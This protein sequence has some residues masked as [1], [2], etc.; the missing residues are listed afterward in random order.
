MQSRR[1]GK[2]QYFKVF[3]KDK[4]CYFKL[5]I[6]LYRDDANYHFEPIVKETFIRNKKKG[7]EIFIENYKNL[8]EDFKS[9]INIAIG[10]NILK[11]YKI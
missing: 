11:L 5:K 2:V 10:E 9:S 7:K 3:L 8:T 1:V 6:Y 4:I